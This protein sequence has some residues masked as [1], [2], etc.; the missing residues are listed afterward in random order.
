MMMLAS[1]TLSG[2]SPRTIAL[3]RSLNWYIVSCR[4]MLLPPFLLP[5]NPNLRFRFCPTT[6]LQLR[7]RG[8]YAHRRPAQRLHSRRCERRVD[9]RTSQSSPER[10][11]HA[12]HRRN[13]RNFAA[14]MFSFTHFGNYKVF[15]YGRDTVH[16]SVLAPNPTGGIEAA[17]PPLT[18]R[19]LKGGQ[20]RKS[21]VSIF[22]TSELGLVWPRDQRL[23]RCR[24]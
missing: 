2:S 6:R 15:T 18:R 5:T 11:F 1:L 16:S 8:S 7:R 17:P 3:R 23:C 24:R 10:V 19:R 13:S 14:C 9:W 21:R 20:L 4:F 22:S 12:L